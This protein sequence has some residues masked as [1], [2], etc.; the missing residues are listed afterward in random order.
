IVLLK[1]IKG[2][3]SGDSSSNSSFKIVNDRNDEQT[4]SGSCLA[5]HTS[6]SIDDESFEQSSVGNSQFI[7]DGNDRVSSLRTSGPSLPREQASIV[8][9]PVQFHQKFVGD[10]TLRR[11]VVSFED[12]IPTV[13]SDDND[14]YVE[15]LNDDDDTIVSFKSPSD[16]DTFVSASK[17]SKDDD[18]LNVSS[19]PFPSDDDTFVFASTASKD[20]DHLCVSSMF[21]PSDNDTFV[22]MSDDDNVFVASMPFLVSSAEDN[23]SQQN[24]SSVLN[25]DEG[26]ETTPTTSTFSTVTTTLATVVQKQSTT[27]ERPGGRQLEKQHNNNN[28]D[29]G[30]NDG[31]DPDNPVSMQGSITYSSSSNNSHNQEQH[32]K[33]VNNNDEDGNIGGMRRSTTTP[34]I[35][36]ENR[37]VLSSNNFKCTIDPHAMATLSY[38]IVQHDNAQFGK[39]SIQDQVQEENFQVTTSIKTD[40]PIPVEA[41]QVPRNLTFQNSTIGTSDSERNQ[42]TNSFCIQSLCEGVLL[43]STDIKPQVQA[44]DQKTKF[45]TSMQQLEEEIVFQDLDEHSNNIQKNSFEFKIYQVHWRSRNHRNSRDNFKF[46]QSFDPN[47]MSQEASNICNAESFQQQ[48]FS[49]KF[50]PS[51]DQGFFPSINQQVRSSLIG[52]AAGIVKQV[53]SHHVSRMSSSSS[54]HYMYK[55]TKPA[56][57]SAIQ[58]LRC[59]LLQAM[60]DTSVTLLLL[61]QTICI[62]NCDLAF[63]SDISRSHLHETKVMTVHRVK[64]TSSAITRSMLTELVFLP[65]RCPKSHDVFDIRSVEQYNFHSPITSTKD[66]Q[67]SCPFLQLKV[68]FSTSQYYL[69]AQ[70][71][72]ISPSRALPLEGVGQSTTKNL[73]V[74][75]KLHPTPPHPKATTTSNPAMFHQAFNASLNRSSSEGVQ[76]CYTNHRNVNPSFNSNYNL[77]EQCDELAFQLDNILWIPL[78][79]VLFEWDEDG[80]PK[81][82][83]VFHENGILN[84]ASNS[85]SMQKDKVVFNEQGETEAAPTV[86][87]SGCNEHHTIEE[88]GA[89]TPEAISNLSRFPSGN[90]Y[91]GYKT[92]NNGD[93]DEFNRIINSSKYVNQL[94]IVELSNINYCLGAI[95]KFGGMFEDGGNHIQLKQ[96]LLEGFDTHKT[97]C[98]YLLSNKQV[99]MQISKQFKSS[100]NVKSFIRETSYKSTDIIFVFKSIEH[101]VNF[102]L[103]VGLDKPRI[104]QIYNNQ[105]VEYTMHHLLNSKNLHHLLS[106]VSNFDTGDPSGELNKSDGMHQQQYLQPTENGIKTIPDLNW[107]ASSVDQVF[108]KHL[109][110]NCQWCISQEELFKSIT[111]YQISWDPFFQ[112]IKSVNWDVSICSNHCLVSS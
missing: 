34:N 92:P 8:R 18:D 63:L 25:G 47:A 59:I 23:S 89:A 64:L 2:L 81:Q 80:G 38:G 29:K 58:C 85:G 43:C 26:V 42:V 77:E 109:F 100:S 44:T 16:N 88:T 19:M 48:N 87:I 55:Q 90:L 51:C 112:C 36:K 66:I 5:R 4:S 1:T 56:I 52:N 11:K 98:W 49:Y 54:L 96:G 17:A 73:T 110:K 76:L 61:N 69:P 39:T 46:I 102:I 94:L 71:T 70:L 83:T 15:S 101:P 91:L 67:S 111:S 93:D 105:Y 3:M 28:N 7:D 12:N 84:T 53:Q 45:V 22:S 21:L 35:D 75:P 30:G 27:M 40:I 74:H 103:Q 108:H 60:E 32:G 78:E 37:C 86:C 79:T 41:Q 82:V 97:P 107:Y 20:D 106:S 57:I 10:G 33:F 14:F 95:I 9:R 13:T 50:S 6:D 65:V 99:A 104:Q 31:R 68:Q 62:I 24:P 72:R